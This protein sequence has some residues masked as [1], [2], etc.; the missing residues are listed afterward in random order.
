M[1]K[2]QQLKR[3]RAVIVELDNGADYALTQF[4]IGEL[5]EIEQALLA[6]DRAKA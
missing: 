6:E 2:D 4:C 3:L 1:N 5:E